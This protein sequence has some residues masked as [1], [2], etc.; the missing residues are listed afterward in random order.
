MY[1]D[2]YGIGPGDCVLHAGAFNWTY[3]LGAGLTD[4]WANGA[5][6]I[7]YTGPREPAIWPRLIASHGATI[8]AAVPTL[9]RQILKYG[10]VSPGALGS[11]R[12]GLMAGEAPP[13][14]LFDEWH[15][16]SGRD[17]HEAF[18]MSELSTFISSAP[19]IPRKPGFIG[20]A[21]SGRHAEILPLDQGEEPLP[22]GQEGLIA[23]HRSD[24]GLMLGYWRRP[25]EE[26]EVFR[27][28]WFIGGDLGTMDYDGYIAHRGRN[29]DIMKAL[30]Y[31]VAPQEVEA[32]LADC[33]GI[34]EVACTEVRVREDLSV[35]GAFVVAVPGNEPLT[36]DRVKAHAAARLA[37]Y[38]CPKAVYFI[39]TMPRTA[40]GKLRRRELSRLISPA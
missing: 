12:H 27:G 38:K 32:A 9:Y 21:Q 39:E 2:W 11:L 22:R 35:I 13:E 6:S 5:T 17:L 29:N 23:M 14:G 4:P 36:A 16:A 30:G 31:R 24:P 1:R 15:R 8:F 19:S 26:R 34:A 25:D 3:T 33:P 37:P 7:V 10:D 40:N 20:R 28:Q 18:G